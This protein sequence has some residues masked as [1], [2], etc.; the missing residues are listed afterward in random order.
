MLSAEAL[1][2]AAERR[3]MI[4]VLMAKEGSADLVLKNGKVVNVL[5]REVYRA[6]VA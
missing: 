1:R 2:E 3:A 5:T 4:D 6:D